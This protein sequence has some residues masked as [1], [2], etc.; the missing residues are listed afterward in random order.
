MTARDIKVSILATVWSALRESAY[1]GTVYETL[2]KPDDLL[3]Y[4]NGKADLGRVRID[5]D[6]TLETESA[7][8]NFAK[9]TIDPDT[10]YGLKVLDD[11][12]IILSIRG[13]RFE[14]K[15]I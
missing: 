1:T 10:V 9:R 15:R 8:I 13:Y 5:E 2:G 7:D 12:T 6:F 14:F 4:I 11:K 3:P